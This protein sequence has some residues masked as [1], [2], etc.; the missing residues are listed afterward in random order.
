MEER[1]Y[2]HD[3]LAGKGIHTLRVILREEFGGTPGTLPKEKLIAKI[4]EIQETKVVPERSTKGRKPYKKESEFP[5]GVV[6][7]M[8]RETLLS[9]DERGVCELNDSTSAHETEL[10]GYF[11]E[12]KGGYGTVYSD[13]K[14]YPK[15][16]YFVPK[17][18]VATYGLRCGDLLSVSVTHGPDIPLVS[19][20][21]K[22]N[23]ENSKPYEGRK[24]FESFDASYPVERL[25]LSDPARDE[26]LLRAAPIG[27]GQRCLATYAIETPKNNFFDEIVRSSASCGYVFVG[28]LTGC[29]PES[30]SALRKATGY[31]MFC[32]TFDDPA[33]RKC[34]FSDLAVGRA[35]RLAEQGKNVVLGIGDIVEVVRSY[36]EFL[37]PDENMSYTQPIK[38]SMEVLRS[39]FATAR[40]LEGGGTLTLITGY[41][42]S[43]A[44]FDKIIEVSCNRMASDKIRLCPDATRGFYVDEKKSGNVSAHIF[45]SDDE[46]RVYQACHSE[47]DL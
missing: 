40:N 34:L 22:I 43:D 46:Y 12:R 6:G 16:E 38:A 2:T 35:K 37:T 19:V 31:E 20:V 36:H 44:P 1:V 11:V 33:E 9:D 39:I 41:K 30:A 4:L 32:S 21:H 5:T 3:M 7:V 13:G 47:V 24:T 28:L 18:T 15:G 25:R 17:A 8:K 23:G 26:E 14:L 27:M 45:L 29:T 10:G 42:I